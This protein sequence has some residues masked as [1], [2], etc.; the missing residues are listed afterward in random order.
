MPLDSRMPLCSSLPFW[1]GLAPWLV[2]ALCLQFLPQA[3]PALAL[4]T[5]LLLWWW[6]KASLNPLDRGILVYF[7]FLTVLAFSSRD[8]D[9]SPAAHF[10]LC[11]ALLAVAAAASV[12][13]RRPFTFL[14]A[15]PYTPAHLRERPAFL[16]AHRWISLL[17][18]VGFAGAALVV[19]LLPGK[20]S[21]LR[22]LLILSASLGGAVAGTVLIGGWFHY[23]S[24]RMLP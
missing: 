4:A 12:V 5:G 7:L 24:C 18:A 21:L 3:A 6:S 1:A 2:F 11:P 20:W 16:A 15:C 13:L 14:Y 10:A 8:Q 19:L 17:W 22:G 9:F 23:R